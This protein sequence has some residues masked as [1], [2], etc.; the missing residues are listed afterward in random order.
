MLSRLS[1]F[2]FLSLALSPV[3]AEKV[4]QLSGQA[5]K[6]LAMAPQDFGSRVVIRDDALEVA[7]EISTINGWKQKEGLLATVKSDQFFRAF[8]D[9]KTGVTTFQVYQY[10]HYFGQRAYFKV[11]NFESLGGAVQKDVTVINRVA[12][13]CSSYLG[14]EHVEH[15]GF[16]VDEAI[17]RAAAAAYRP[18]VL[19]AWH[20]RLK[21]KSGVQRDE[22]FVGAEIVALLQAVDKY[23]AEKGLLKLGSAAP[24]G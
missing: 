5:R 11:V 2:L 23:K 19:A 10:I 8:V 20:Y 24:G 21:S 13:G 18:G 4:P 6:L 17:L 9:K 16:D 12:L 1:T 7:A 3:Q 22:G 14:C 15:I